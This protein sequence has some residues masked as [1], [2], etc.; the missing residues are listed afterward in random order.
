MIIQLLASSKLHDFGR[1]T[2]AAGL[3]E[4]VVVFTTIAEAAPALSCCHTVIH[5]VFRVVKDY[6]RP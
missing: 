4:R 5:C 2:V 6:L 3:Q 1:Q